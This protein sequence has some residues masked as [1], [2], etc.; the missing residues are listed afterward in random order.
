VLKNA[1]YF[2]LVDE[3]NTRSMHSKKTPRGAGIAFGLSIFL[4]LIFFDFLHL[5][6]FYYIYIA[7]FLVWLVGILDDIKDVS[8]KLKFIFILLASAIL[9]S[10]NYAIYNLGIYFD[11]EVI[12]PTWIAYIFT[13]FAIAGYTNALNLM[14]GL[15]GLAASISLVMLITFYVIGMQHNDALLTSLSSL[16]IASLLAFLVFNWNP[17]KI[18]MGDSGSLTLG[19]VI[20]LLTIEASK[21]IS[22][23]AILF[24]IALPLLDTFIVMVR[25]RQRHRSL[26]E[27]DKNHLHHFL[28]HVKGDTRF[29]VIMLITMQTIFSIIG[30]Q[31]Q[32]S[33]DLLS[34][35]LF[36]LLFYVYFNLF[37]QRLKRRSKK[38]NTK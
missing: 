10:K 8:P 36:G 12:L 23:A 4:S 24:I 27:A 3:P 32:H 9:F 33:N 7:I 31:V 22:P 21:Y 1:V 20:S 16:F 14:D 17:A 6:E 18:F 25:R 38:K 5:K 2:G 15:D 19:F 28:F 11:Y 37:D 29:T 35:I 34:I 30:F 26:F 13:F